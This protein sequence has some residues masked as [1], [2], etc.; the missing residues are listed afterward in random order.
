MKKSVF[1]LCG[2]L[3]AMAVA[4]CTSTNADPAPQSDPESM[5]IAEK[6]VIYLY[7]KEETEVSVQLDV[8]GETLFTY[9]AYENGWEV[10]AYP[11]GTLL[12]DGR[13]YS[14]LFWDAALQAEYDMSQG[15]VVKG[16]DTEAFLVEKLQYLGL[17][18]QEYNEFLVY[19][20][21][22]MV[23]NNY[24]LITF[25]EEAYTDN[26][27]LT[28]TPQP[29]SMQRVFMVYKPL[30]EEIEI[31]EQTLMPFERSGFAVIEWGGLELAS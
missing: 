18:P 28:I 23:G 3:L 12:S 30:Q 8:N 10:T 1:L 31:E 14:Y 27:V 13:M 11:D 25:Q 16:E 26:A 21:P 7:P 2:L 22:R 15:F 6:P 24:N 4:G 19:W 5:P 9:P 17:T 29:D 20:L